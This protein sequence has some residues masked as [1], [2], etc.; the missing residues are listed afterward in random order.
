MRG[1]LWKRVMV[2]TLWIDI[3]MVCPYNVLMSS[4]ES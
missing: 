2:Y 3:Y 4:D 1:K